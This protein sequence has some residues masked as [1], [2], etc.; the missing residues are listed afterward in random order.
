ML[1]EFEEKIES[2]KLLE[3]ELD[4]LIKLEN[5]KDLNIFWKLFKTDI[6]LSSI[7]LDRIDVLNEADW[8]FVEK[9]FGD[10]TNLYSEIKNID[11]KKINRKFLND[12]I[13]L[14]FE[15]HFQSK[16]LSNILSKVLPKEKKYLHILKL[17]YEII[18][19]D[20]NYFKAFDNFVF[21]NLKVV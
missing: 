20:T 12:N 6:F 19:T 4:T 5:N 7:I 21:P 1:N 8:E 13:K 17:Y 3:L 2:V 18:E 11:F 16:F 14:F 15:Y 10:Y 9:H